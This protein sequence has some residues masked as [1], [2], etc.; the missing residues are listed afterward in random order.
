[1]DIPPYQTTTWMVAPM[2]HKAMHI[3]IQVVQALTSL[4][5]DLSGSKFKLTEN[6]A[7]IICAK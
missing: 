6:Q 2:T 1:M 4:Q 5:N 7:K 3:W